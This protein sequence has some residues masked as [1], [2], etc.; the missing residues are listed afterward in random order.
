MS[1]A[2]SSH[3]TSFWR[4]GIE[5][6]FWRGT[7]PLS[8]RAN[9]TASYHNLRSRTRLLIGT[10][11]SQFLR[12]GGLRC[13]PI[14]VNIVCCSRTRNSQDSRK[15]AGRYA[16][17]SRRLPIKQGA[18]ASGRAWPS[19]CLAVISIDSARFSRGMNC[20][21]ARCLDVIDWFWAELPE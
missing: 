7:V 13:G 15:Q 5:L 3:I 2:A 14:P 17:N 1:Y 20:L 8:A 11:D 9:P 4:V 10:L 19:C 18:R 16:W 21:K 6:F 12:N